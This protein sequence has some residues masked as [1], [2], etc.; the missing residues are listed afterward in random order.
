MLIRVFDETQ[1]AEPGLLGDVLTR[2]A[3]HQHVD[4]A[5]IYVAPRE[6]NGWAEYILV[7]KYIDAGKLTIGCLQ[8][9]SGAKTEFHT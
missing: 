7:I 3:Q 4:H 2:L 8:R 5:E 6:P 9:S 1:I